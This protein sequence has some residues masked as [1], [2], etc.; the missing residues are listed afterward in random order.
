[1]NKLSIL[2]LTTVLLSIGIVS[3]AQEQGFQF[4][5][6]KE[7]KASPVK[8]QQRTGT[9]WSFATTSFIESELLRMGKPLFDISEMFF[10]RQAYTSKAI[11]YVRYQGHNNFSQGGQ[12]HD[13]MDV[14]RAKGM[15]TE[16]EYS[17]LNYGSDIHAHAELESALKAYLGAIVE[18]PNR[19]LSTAWLPAFNTVLDA[20]LGVS[21]NVKQSALAGVNF[22]PD[23]YIEITSFS[24][25]PYYSQFILEIPDNWAH[26]SYYNVPLEEFIKIMKNAIMNGYSV[27]W[28]GDVSEKGFAYNKGVAVLP[29]DRVEEMSGSDKERWIGLSEKERK[30]KLFSF[31]NPVPEIN[32]D[33]T[34]RQQNFDNLASTDDHLMHLTGLAT[35]QNGTAYFYTKNSWG[36]DGVYNGY[37]YMSEPFVRMKT[38]AIMIHKDAL[39]AD[40]AKKL[41][42]K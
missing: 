37:L 8:N 27:C 18:N 11:D 28:D 1:M 17:G 9:C 12:A 35:D 13:V 20:Y 14:I 5:M 36:T 19:K 32:V 33:Q 6:V 2:L 15:V 42:I 22:N 29:E 4:N 23:D 3:F 40:I 16:Q 41:G 21:P 38:I 31:E 34:N 7:V 30:T 25:H 10:A 26:R 24:H 39:P